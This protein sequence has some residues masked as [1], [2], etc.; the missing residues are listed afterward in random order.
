[1]NNSDFVAKQVTIF[2]ESRHYFDELK[3]VII[4]SL[5]GFSRGLRGM[6]FVHGRTKE[7]ASYAEKCIRKQ[8]KYQ[9]PAWQL[10]DPTGVRIIVETED[11]LAPVCQ[12]IRSNFEID[13]ANS[14]DKATELRESEFGYHSIHFIVSLKPGN[15][16]PLPNISQELF[17]WR[18]A[19]EAKAMGILPGPIFKAEIQVKTLLDHAWSN[20]LHDNL[21]KID[22]NKRPRPVVREASRLAATLEKMDT[23]FVDLLHSIDEYR[24]YYGAYL[25]PEKIEAEMQTQEIVLSQDRGNKAVALKIAQ[26]ANFTDNTVL[27]Q[28]VVDDILTDFLT[29]DDHRFQREVGKI[30]YRLGQVH[31]AIEHLTNATELKPDDTDNW[32]E[33]GQVYQEQGNYSSAKQCFESAFTIHPEYPRALLGYIVTKL[34]DGDNNTFLPLLRHNLLQSITISEKRIDAGTHIPFAWYDIG[35]AEL[36]LGNLNKCIDAFGK[37]ILLSHSVANVAKTYHTLTGLHARLKDSREFADL[38]HVVRAYFRVILA[39]RY[40]KVNL[41]MLEAYANN[42][43][44]DER[45]TTVPIDRCAELFAKDRPVVIVAGSCGA[46]FSAHVRTYSSILTTAFENFSGTICSGGTTAGISGIVGDL[47]DPEGKIN[48]IAYLPDPCPDEGK[49]HSAYTLR[50]TTTK[51]N[52][53]NYSILDAIILWGDIVASGIAPQ[54]VR[55]LGIGGGDISAF[56]Y[57]LALLLNAKVGILPKSGRAAY[58]ISNDDE[59]NSVKTLTYSIS[60]ETT[61]NA[62]LGLI[63]LPEDAETVRAFINPAPIPVLF[64]TAT[65]DAMAQ[66]VHEQFIGGQRTVLVNSQPNL[67][68]WEQLDETYKAA[69]YAQIDIIIEKI[70]RIGLSVRQV[71]GRDI[72]NFDIKP[73]IDKLAEIEHGNWNMNRLLNGWSF[74]QERDNTKKIHPSLIPWVGLPPSEKQKDIDFANE[75]PSMLAAVGFEIFDPK[76]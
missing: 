73:Y 54:D 12:Y 52:P 48:K 29:S 21:Y 37:A 38:F 23:S 5:D 26:M 36:F 67:R 42:H 63:Q 6:S 16:Y 40:E 75:I 57:R 45:L 27:L 56:E 61:K 44:Q 55:L 17:Q 10:T 33:L 7:I 72:V 69:N 13:E 11:L 15:P 8:H 76:V 28:H 65:R 34:L 30:Q 50:R 53:R 58:A 14:V 20:I 2:K 9:H 3:N 31:L 24:S 22:L 64:D 47:P 74:G 71:T 32:C 1:M 60:E 39:G 62:R 41:K 68:D 43:C 46:E 59:W 35:F 49:I 25:S 70:R 51:K 66:R 19:E 18:S 4:A